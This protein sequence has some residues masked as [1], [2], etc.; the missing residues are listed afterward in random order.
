[1]ERQ[2]SSA[3]Q[4]QTLPSAVKTENPWKKGLES[5]I[6]LG[7]SSKS[8][9]NMERP[10]SPGLEAGLSQETWERTTH[11]FLSVDHY[12]SDLQGQSLLGDFFP[13][14]EEGGKVSWIQIGSSPNGD[15]NRETPNSPGPEAGLGSSGESWERTMP[16]FLSMDHNSADIQ[17][18]RFRHSSYREGEGP[19]EVC[20][21][22][23]SLGRQWLKPEQHTKA[24][25]LDLVILEQFL[26]ILPPE[27]GSWVRE[28]GAETS[29]QAVALAEGF[30]LS[31]AQE[32]R[33][34]EMPQVQESFAYENNNVEKSLSDTICVV[35]VGGGEF[36]PV[37]NETWPN[38][39]STS[40]HDSLLRRYSERP[41]Q[42]TFEDVD[43]D[44]TEEEWALLDPGQRALYQQ[45]KEENLEIVSF[46]EATPFKSLEYGKNFSWKEQLTCH[47]AI[48]RPDKPFKC[49]E[50][51]KSYCHKRH[52][53]RHRSIH[54]GQKPFICFE[55]GKIFS[56]KSHLVVH[57]ATHTGE[58][59]FICFECGKSFS[60]KS[61]LVVHQATHTGE[62]PFKCS[63]CGKSFCQKIHLVRHQYTHTGEKPFMCSECGK[64]FSWKA[65]LILHQTTHTGE[66]PFMCLECGKRFSQKSHLIFHQGTHTGEKPFK[67]SECGKTFSRKTSLVL[68]QSTHGE[69]PLICSECGKNFSQ[70]AE[71]VRHQATH[72]REKPFICSACGKSF[73]QK[74]H[75]VF[76][77]GT[78]TGD[79]PFKCSE[80]GKCFRRKS[81]LVIHQGTH[82]GE[83]PFK[84]SECGKSFGQKAHLVRHQATHTGEKPFI[85][86]EC[87]KSFSQKRNLMNH[88]MCHTVV[89]VKL[90]EDEFPFFTSEIQKGPESLSQSH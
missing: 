35:V 67:C 40:F 41:D 17:C 10:N 24:E 80:C 65:Y 27:M 48:H 89:Q 16:K 73:S 51:G 78:H 39:S 14:K 83:K 26:S 6:P 82:T 64:S 56:Q 75:L 76:H 18:Q 57:Q 45:V 19:R 85:C 90:E 33:K 23:H 38:G 36:I 81:H 47:P 53:I 88:Q 20:S 22:L 54:T 30:L 52:L 9:P 13:L 79:K 43:V 72:T 58:R 68:H 55:C 50:C 2:E 4:L 71:L 84:C 15:C 62:K 70:K 74:S 5:R 21:R 69:K 7:S 37:G 46:L 87:G 11:K 1:M 49:L 25:M 86:L 28:C 66:K 29:S 44:F 60:Q 61:N 3:S 8:G 59:P 31:R 34:L 42:V 77:Q 63:E 12:S 32:E